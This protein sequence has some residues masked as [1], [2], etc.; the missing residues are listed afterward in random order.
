[1]GPWVRLRDR[2]RARAAAN[3]ANEATLAELLGTDEDERSA[4]DGPWSS[5]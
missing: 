2:I 3:A 5:V 4:S 1:M